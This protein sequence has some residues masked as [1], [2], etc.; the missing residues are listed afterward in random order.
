M[1]S[2][3]AALA[4]LVVIY[5]LFRLDH[6]G[7]RV[8][9]AVWIPFAWLLIESSRPISGWLSAPVGDVADTYIDGSPLDRNVLTLLLLLAAFVL[10]K[11]M[12][13]VRGFLALN[14]P[15]VVYFAYC[16]LSLLWSDYPF[17]VFKRWI[18]SVADVMMVL[19]ILSESD[20]VAALSRVLTTLTYILIP[21]S[22]LFIRFFPSLGRFYSRGGV[23]EWTGVGTDKNALG[24]ICMLFGVFTLW[25]LLNPEKEGLPKSHIRRRRVA[26]IAAFLMIIYLL[27]VV[28]SQTA[29][30][31]F[32][33]ACIVVVLASRTRW[34]LRPANAS[35]LVWGMVAASCC[36]LFLG[37]GGIV[38]TA[39]GRD[40]SLT[41]RTDVWRTVL[42]YA[43]NT[44]VGAG[45]E[46]F[47]IGDRMRLFERLLG[48]LNQA[49]NGYIEVYLNIGVVG[50]TLLAAIIVVGYQNILYGLQRDPRAGGLRMAFFMICL[51]Y[52]FTEAS[53]KMMSPVWLLFIL[54][55]AALP[56]NRPLRAKTA[57]PLWEPRRRDLWRVSP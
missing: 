37:V 4:N 17:V 14:T 29:L 3:L 55:A 46:N 8:S 24:M 9:R 7:Q 56:M 53:F 2:A 10:S 19:I 33:M 6:G 50:L 28:N 48:G 27:L 30:A 36:V 51:I 5:V 12:Y 41:G 38:L 34:F 45:Y 16:L 25:R 11:R 23:P 21:T 1:I 13:N 42:P 40:A 43:A 32:A 31:C 20:W 35:V 54:S 44:W 39:L 49:H 18:R 22:I 52:N 15:M 47:W 57:T 26:L